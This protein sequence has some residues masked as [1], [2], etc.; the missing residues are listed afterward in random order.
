MKILYRATESRAARKRLI[1]LQ[2]ERFH[3]EDTGRIESEK[4]TDLFFPQPANR[5][6]QKKETPGQKERVPK[7]SES[8]RSE[9]VLEA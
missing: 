9:R 7:N 2:T 3:A 1:I 4:G 6:I 8:D 5:N